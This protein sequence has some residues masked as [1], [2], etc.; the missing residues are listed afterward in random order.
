MDVV[1][2]IFGVLRPNACAMERR[3]ALSARSLFH[4]ASLPCLL[5]NCISWLT[6]SASEINRAIEALGLPMEEFDDDQWQSLID[7]VFS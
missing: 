3:S 4:Q 6:S 2:T 5:S 1:R 7:M